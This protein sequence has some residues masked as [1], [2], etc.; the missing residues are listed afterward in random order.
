MT[1]V[2]LKRMSVILGKMKK[3]LDM[4]SDGRLLKGSES[5]LR[6]WNDSAYIGMICVLL[7]RFA[8][9]VCVHVSCYNTEE[10]I[11]EKKAPIYF[12]VHGAFAL[13]V[14]R[15]R[16]DCLADIVNWYLNFDIDRDL[17]EFHCQM[18]LEDHEILKGFGRDSFLVSF[19]NEFGQMIIHPTMQS[20]FCV[21]QGFKKIV[22]KYGY[23]ASPYDHMTI[24]MYKEEFDEE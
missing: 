16:Y 10:V 18:W 12:S 2:A 4:G 15:D 11:K 22:E 20:D 19:E 21:E 1:E 23:T 3:H 24:V 7:R 9:P 14:G 8:F 5:F 17:R 13:N 6:Q